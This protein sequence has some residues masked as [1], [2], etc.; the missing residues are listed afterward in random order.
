MNLNDDKYKKLY[1]HT[2]LRVGFPLNGKTSLYIPRIKFCE[3]T[4]QYLLKRLKTEVKNSIGNIVKDNDKIGIPLSGGI[5]SSVITFLIS[6]IYPDRELYTYTLAS[7]ENYGIDESSDA[8]IVAERCGTI[9]KT[10]YIDDES[11]IKLIKESTRLNPF[12]SVGSPFHFATLKAMKE[13]NINAVIFGEGGDE[14]LSGYYPGNYGF[15]GYMKYYRFFPSSR[16]SSLFFSFMKGLTK[17][18]LY[19]LY[20]K[21]MKKMLKLDV[22][23]K[24]KIFFD[25]FKD[26]VLPLD[27]I[28]LTDTFNRRQREEIIFCNHFDF[29]VAFPFLSSNDFIDF[30]YSIPNRLRRNELY[31]KLILRTALKDIFPKQ[32]V[33]KKKTGFGLG[34]RIWHTESFFSF[35]ES[36]FDDSMMLEE[37]LI[38]QSFIDKYLDKNRQDWR[39]KTL[40][41]IL[42]IELCY[43][44][45]AGK[46]LGQ[47]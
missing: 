43:R 4:P 2:F 33:W 13:D 30:C 41:R 10:I 38:K 7:Q 18:R 24:F 8:K 23:S 3:P 36:V 11:Y 31:G 42:L 25:F 14:I 5:D 20:G 6:E 37:K 17:W 45:N 44:T 15:E 22:F 12:S 26:P 16:R 21:E 28:E 29:K 19:E 9:H 40:L 46:S 35:M 32:I 39:Y 47:D 1:F 27:L 34:S